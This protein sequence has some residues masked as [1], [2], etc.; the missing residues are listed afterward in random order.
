VSCYKA[1]GRFF[2]ATP[3]IET[4]IGN[5][6]LRREELVED[7]DR[8]TPEE[9]PDVEGHAHEPVLEDPVLKKDDEEDFEAHSLRDPVLAD[10]VMRGDEDD[11]DPVL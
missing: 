4:L 11:K 1:E 5:L 7:Q 9:E 10:P 3:S 8:K 6:Q 2:G